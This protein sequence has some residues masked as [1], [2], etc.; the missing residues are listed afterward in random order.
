MHNDKLVQ[1][2]LAMREIGMRV[3]DRAI[4]MARTADLAEYRAISYGELASLFATFTTTV[5]AN[6]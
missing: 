5:R 4:R 3:D 6:L 1:E 2:L